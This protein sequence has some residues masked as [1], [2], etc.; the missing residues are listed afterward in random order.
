MLS[1]MRNAAAV[2]VVLLI[3]G[4]MFCAAAQPP[5]RSITPHMTELIKAHREVI[6]GMNTPGKDGRLRQLDEAPMRQLLAQGWQ[7]DGQWAGAWFDLH[8][9]PS[10]KD[11]DKLFADFS[12]PPHYPEVYDPKLPDLYAMAG[13]ATRIAPGIYVVQ[14]DYE[15]SQSANAAST[16]FVVARDTDGHFA[17]KWSVKSL[18]ERHY[19]KKDEIGLWAFLG[20]CAY[21]CGALVVDQILPLPPSGDLPRF[22]VDAV[23]ATNGNT[24]MKQLSVWQ[25]NGT[26]AENLVIQS[27]RL[28]A[29]D[30]R[31]IRLVD[32]LLIVPT[33]EITKSFSSY[34]CCAEP[35]G[36]WTI[37]IAPDR[38]QNLGH[39]FLQPQIQWADRLL[40]ATGSKSSSATGLASPSVIAYL[41]H[42]EIE[43]DAVDKCHVLRS[44]E[45]GVFEISFGAGTKLRLAYTL[46]K[47]R[48][49]FTSVRAQ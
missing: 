38:T 15:E 26:E 5:I 11:L 28:G 36:T 39:R 24:L 9:D 35:R 45:K 2:L 20:S 17:S 14:A 40:A 12:P 30:D 4:T 22:A 6:H 46:R 25:W 16:F 21:Y 27:Y 43:T 3:A 37:R 18:A 29:E 49:Y 44:G 8:P 48:P 31:A 10:V 41:K 33:K 34:G 32:D 13:S 23:Q 47:G 1:F 42:T 7:L 19:S